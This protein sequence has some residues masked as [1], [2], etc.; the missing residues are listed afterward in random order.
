M[1]RLMRF[2]RDQK[3]SLVFE[4]IDMT[5]DPHIIDYAE[6]KLVLLGC[7]RRHETFEQPGY[8]DLVKLASWLGCEVKERIFPKIKDWPALSRSEEHTS[9]LQSLMRISLS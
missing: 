1:E 9:E 8:D 7:V 5:N 3:A 4:A 2:N 6:N